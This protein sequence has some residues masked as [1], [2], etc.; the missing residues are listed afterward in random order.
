MDED[1]EREESLRPSPLAVVRGVEME[2]E[3]EVWRGKGEPDT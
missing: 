1:E 2:G 3:G